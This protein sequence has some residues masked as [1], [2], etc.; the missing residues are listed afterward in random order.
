MTARLLRLLVALALASSIAGVIPATALAAPVVT[1]TTPVGGQRTNDTTPLV[2]GTGGT[3]ADDAS[4]IT[5]DVY[6]GTDTSAPPV[7]SFVVALSGGN[8]SLA[9]A[10]W[11]A[12]NPPLAEGDYTLIAT[13]A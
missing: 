13:Q 3:S 6:S 1:I 7:R 8:W 12:G 2:A 5:L 9:D 4:S 10:A 11:D